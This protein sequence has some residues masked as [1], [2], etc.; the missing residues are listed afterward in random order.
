M[1]STPRLRARTT[2]VPLSSRLGK[3]EAR[4]W[5]KVCVGKQTRKT[6]GRTLTKASRAK[7]VWMME[8]ISTLVTAS[9][10]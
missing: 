6:I 7:A 10:P 3:G 2:V 1:M 4:K 9:F 8:G 5:R